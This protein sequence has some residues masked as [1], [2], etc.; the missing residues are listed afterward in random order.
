MS[1]DKEPIPAEEEEV[2]FEAVEEEAEPDP[3]SDP[4]Y[5]IP[6]D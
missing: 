2:S 3:T 1:E 6:G 5:P 4:D